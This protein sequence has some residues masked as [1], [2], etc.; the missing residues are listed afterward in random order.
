MLYL[1]SVI[2]F[3]FVSEWIILIFFL[4]LVLKD[5]GFFVLF[6][7]LFNLD[8]GIINNGVEIFSKFN[9]FDR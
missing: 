9:F 1:Y 3:Y 6:K 2:F 5:I 7:L 8:F 4:F